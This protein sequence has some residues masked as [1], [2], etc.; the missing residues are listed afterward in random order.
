MTL[1]AISEDPLDPLAKFR[2]FRGSSSASS[3]TAFRECPK[4]M[5]C[6]DRDSR[7]GLARAVLLPLG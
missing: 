7:F 4:R 6:T 5:D 3:N 2:G 1:T